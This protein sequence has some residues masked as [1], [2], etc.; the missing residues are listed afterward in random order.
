M[1][2]LFAILFVMFLWAGHSWGQVIHNESFDGATFVPSGWTDLLTSGTNTW[3]RVT[4]G[5]YPTQAPHSGAGEAKFDSW[6]TNSG[7]RSL[8]TPSF[9]LAGNT[10]GAAVS[11]WMYRDNGYNTTADKIDVYYNT[12]ANLTGAT[13]LGTVNRAIG[14]APIVGANGWYQY[15]YTIP[16]TQ[17]SATE[18][19]ILKATSVYGNNIFIDDVSWTEYPT[20]PALSAVPSSLSFGYNAYP[21][22]SASQTYSLSGINLTAG[23]IAV[24]A[25]A[26]F[27]VSLD[28]STWSSSVNVSYTIP[29]LASTT[30]YAHFVPLAAGINYSGNIT[31]VGGGSTT[32]VAVTGNSD[33]F[34]L[35]CAS[36]ATNSG[37]EDITNV[38]FGSSLNNTSGC[39]SLTGTQGTATGTADLYSNFTSITPTDVARTLSVPISVQIT[40]CAGTAYT[41]NVRVYIDFNQNGSLADAGEE[42]IIFPSASS[43]THTINYSIPIPAGATLGNTLMRIVCK[44][45]TTTGP[46]VVSSYGETEDYKINIISP[47]CPTPSALTSTSITPTQATLGWTE[48]G[49]STSWDIEWGAAGFIQGTGT[50]IT[51]VTNPYILTGLAAATS[52]SYYVRANCGGGSYSA[53]AASS[54]FTTPCTNSTLP[55]TQG[56]NAVTIPTCWSQQYVS[57]TSNIQYLASSSYPTTTPQE[58]ADYVYWNSYSYSAGTETRLVSAPITTTG[59]NSVD[60]NFYW[61]Y[62]NSTSY[63]TGAY[64]NEGVTV[65]YS[66]DGSTWNDVQ[67]VARYDASL[68]SGTSLWKLKSITLPVGAA[69]QPVIYVGFKFHS[70]WGDNCSMDNLTVQAT[71]AGMWSGLV[72]SDWGTTGNWTSLSLPTSGDNVIINSGAPNMPVVNAAPATPAVCNALT[73]NTGATLTIAAASALTASGATTNNGTFTLASD[74]TGTGSFI[75]NGT[76]AGTGTF[77]VDKYLTGSGGPTPNGAYWYIGSPVP[78]ATSL[79]FA[80]SGDNR[81]WSYS[82][83]PTQGY[84]EITTDGVNLNPLQGYVARL[85]AT[86]T[87]DFTG[88]SLNTGSI[89]SVG[90]LTRSIVSVYDGFNLV[91][92]PYPSAINFDNAGVGLTRTNIDNTIW[93]RNGGNFCTYNWLSAVGVPVTTTQYVPAMQSFWVWVPSGTNG[94]LQ[95]TNAARTHSTQAF[96]KTN[97]DN[98]FRMDL[99]NGNLTD[100]AVVAFFQDAVN[101]YDAYDSKKMFSPENDYPQIATIT[102]DYSVVVI[103][104]Q[105][106]IGGTEERVIPMEIKTNVSGSFTLNAN[107][108]GDFN[109]SVSVYLE[110]AEMGI[111]QDLRQNPN[112]TFTSGISDNTTRFKL[113]FGTLTTTSVSNLTANSAITIYEYNN[114]V[115]VNTH[116][117]GAGLIEIYD[118]LGEKILS[119][120]SV[121]GLNVLQPKVV[122]G[123]YIVKV[124]TDGKS[125]TQK[126]I[127]SK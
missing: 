116:E 43:N 68:T 55:L 9:S 37:D 15:T 2:K 23:P 53:W 3:T 84:T 16:G 77:H 109:S 88:T 74:A 13:L 101:N 121:K 90:N 63:N 107:N 49:S 70:E 86:S 94:T 47:A 123:I 59:I 118:M 4:T 17:T 57:G 19:L 115:Y 27:E 38:T 20:T 6:T 35:Y 122:N 61:M 45:S 58:G 104:G 24:T 8:V 71:P 52:Y 80:A 31:N 87:I 40:E 117:A 127:L 92:N 125:V 51:G 126:V 89:G 98:I 120:Q 85:G 42:F 7:V 62:E 124:L 75:D 110:D 100:Q 50:T 60:V 10:T 83:A 69:N 11:F 64:L 103:N 73:I 91:S 36:A 44:E 67:F 78:S 119:Q 32:N 65:Q 14:L 72:S 25:P 48:N 97:T 96:Y 111:L 30:I 1:R 56:F 33:V 114:A 28:G 39:A 99:T 41:H 54:T 113:H 12:A 21:G 81:L 18:Y 106:V 22:T 108:I 76:I 5:T 93:F 79:V 112:Y 66:T 34:S 29:T 95:V 26:G 105:S 102:P 82:E 46:C